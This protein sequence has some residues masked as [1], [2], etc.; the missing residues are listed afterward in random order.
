MEELLERLCST[1][2]LSE[3]CLTRLRQVIKSQ[4]LA[5]G[6]HL[7]RTGEVCR[8]IYY[9]SKGFL[10]CYYTR[11]GSDAEV[12]DW[13]YMEHEF[14]VSIP[15]YYLQVPSD[16]SIHA[17]EDCELFYISFEEER[18][19]N[20]DFIEFN[21]VGRLWT[22]KYLMDFSSLLKSIRM[23]TAIERYQLLMER[24]PE[25]IERVPVMYLASYMNMDAK[26]MSRMRSQISK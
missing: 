25:L 20:R 9:I 3:G 8:N 13:L 17:V 5:E 11:D 1:Y 6:D 26:T 23:L 24:S 12:T 16:K 7:L 2:P 22:M 18:A 14:I 21:V 19:L 15:S 10:R 4:T